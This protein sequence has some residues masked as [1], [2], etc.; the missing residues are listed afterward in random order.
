MGGMA[1]KNW[2]V[3]LGDLTWVVHDND[4]GNEG[5]GLL[6][7]VVLGVRGDE[8]SLELLD[9]NVL[10]VESDIVTWAGLWEGLVVHL[11]GFDLSGHV[12]WSESD[13]HTGLDLAS[14]D[15]TDWDCSDTTDLV[16]ILEWETKWLK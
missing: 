4:L 15:T 7:W 10:D 8:S 3:S 5:S 16:D 1:I 14:L 11:D 13:D 12:G 9:G 2:A 6:G